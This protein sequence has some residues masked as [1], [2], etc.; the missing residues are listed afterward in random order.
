MYM[1]YLRILKQNVWLSVM[2][3]RSENEKLLME[4]AV[5]KAGYCVRILRILVYFYYRFYYTIK[6]SQLKG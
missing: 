5:V 6:T 1:D 4:I 3:V 2:E